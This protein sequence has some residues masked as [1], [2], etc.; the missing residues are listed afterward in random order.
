MSYVKLVSALSEESL[1]SS[2]VSAYEIKNKNSVLSLRVGKSLPLRDNKT[3]K[4]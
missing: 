4:L 1:V 2:C 3:V